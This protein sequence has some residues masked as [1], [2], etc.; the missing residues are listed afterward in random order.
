M[1]LSKA[2]KF[3]VVLMAKNLRH[4]SEPQDRPRGIHEFVMRNPM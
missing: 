4:S 3:Y 1:D 2:A